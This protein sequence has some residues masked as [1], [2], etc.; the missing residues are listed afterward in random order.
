MKKQLKLKEEKLLSLLRKNISQISFEEH[1]QILIHFY[2]P[3]EPHN[4]SVQLLNWAHMVKFCLKDTKFY[5]LFLYSYFAYLGC[6]SHMIFLAFNLLI[7]L[8]LYYE[9]IS[10]V[11]MSLSLNAAQLLFTVLL[12]NILIFNYAMFGFNLISD[13]FFFGEILPNGENMCTSAL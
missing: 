12:M 10:I 3:I 4:I 1:K 8:F 6:T 5:T 11:Y 2:E 13:N 9:N 7:D